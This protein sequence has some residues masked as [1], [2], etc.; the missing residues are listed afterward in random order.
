MYIDPKA[1][2]RPASL[3]AAGGHRPGTIPATGR[4]GLEFERSAVSTAFTGATLVR[5]AL[6]CRM[7]G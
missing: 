3:G 7:G 6:G 4:I 2:P 1:P 5:T